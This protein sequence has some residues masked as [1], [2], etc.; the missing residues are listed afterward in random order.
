MTLLD[1]GD[2]RPVHFVGIAGAGM[3]ALAELFRRRGVM[4]T[5]V[6]RR[7]CGGRSRSAGHWRADG[8]DPA[9]PRRRA[10]VVTSAVPRDHPELARAELGLL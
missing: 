10:V 1:S 2:G 6:M 8:H 9:H 5:D 3:R 7:R 4:V